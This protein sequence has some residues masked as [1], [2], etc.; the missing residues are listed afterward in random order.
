MDLTIVIPSFGLAALLRACIVHASVALQRAGLA[1]VC[2]AVV[3]NGGLEP[4]EANRFE[5]PGLAFVRLDRRSS[6]SRACN[7]GAAARVSQRFLFLNNDV[8]LHPDA[9]GEMLIL[10]SGRNIGVCGARL[11]Y[12]DDRIQHCGV[13]FHADLRGPH[14]EFH[15]LP[16]KTVSRAVRPFQAVT[17][18]ALLI[19]GA[20]FAR[21]GGFDEA[22]PF[23]FEDVDLCLRA[24]LEG[25]EITCSQGVDSLHFESTSNRDPRRLDASRTVFFDRWAGRYT[26]D[27]TAEQEGSL[28]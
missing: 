19:D 1:Q 14:H 8:L 11:V 18:A 6:F 21:L 22:F 3:D 2:I 5:G 4:Y 23:G 15:G 16:T 24:R 17:G 27:L 25:V 12:P 9:I 26:A 7:A 10:S 20:L 28:P 13:R